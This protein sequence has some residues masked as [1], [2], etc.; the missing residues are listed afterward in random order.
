MDDLEDMMMMEA[1]RLSLA[2]EEERRRKEEKEAKKDAK[3]KEKENKK[4]EKAAKKSGLYMMN[5]NTSNGDPAESVPMGRTESVASS[6]ASEDAA[7]MGKGKGVD[8]VGT[9][10][11]SIGSSSHQ[12]TFKAPS[13][14]PG[15]SLS[16]ASQ[17]SLPSP[18]PSFPSEPAR[19]SHLRQMS[20]A[21]SSAS[22][23]VDPSSSHGYPGTG[24]PPG[25]GAGIEP[26]FNFRSLAAMI[27]DEEKGNGPSHFE[28]LEAGLRP[29]SIEE[30]EDGA[31]SPNAPSPTDS[32]RSSQIES[33][34][35]VNGK[36]GQVAD[37]TKI[38]VE[39]KDGGTHH[40]QAT[41]SG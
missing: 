21:S 17:E 24:T 10:P 6:I 40:A 8:R 23:F 38:P 27:G 4:A 22:S 35:Q 39:G 37:L 5:S 34:N 20:N 13:D 15:I 28:H 30:R 29:G 2:S 18:F 9:L 19:R 16:G 36:A 1:I 11:I 33:S 7:T 3:K 12:S 32:S 41:T 14:P 26:M 31:G 25:G